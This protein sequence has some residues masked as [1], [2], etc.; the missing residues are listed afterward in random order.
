MYILAMFKMLDKHLLL[1]K[2]ILRY[3]QEMWLGPRVDELLY[4]LIV[5]LISFF[6]KEDYSNIDFMEILSKRLKLIW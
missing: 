3:L 1:S 4:F 6:K 5:F 2:I